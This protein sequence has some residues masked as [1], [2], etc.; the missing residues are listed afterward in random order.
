M[1][2]HPRL[3]GGEGNHFVIKKIPKLFHRRST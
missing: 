3:I 1:L 2:F